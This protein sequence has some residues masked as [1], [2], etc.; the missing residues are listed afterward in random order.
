M[1]LAQACCD[2]AAEVAAVGREAVVDE[3]VHQL[4]PQVMHVSVGEGL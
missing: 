1:V 4:H 3:P 2:A